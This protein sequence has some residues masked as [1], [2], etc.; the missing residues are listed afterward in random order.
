MSVSILTLVVLCVAGGGLL[1]VVVVTALAVFLVNRD[2]PR[3][4]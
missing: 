4:R 3:D 1:L 2:L